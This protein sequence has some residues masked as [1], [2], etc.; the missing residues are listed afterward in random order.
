MA[1]PDEPPTIN[2]QDGLRSVYGEPLDLAVA[3]VRDHLDAHHV[4]FIQHSP[5]LCLSSVDRDGFPTV[6]PK[7]DAPGFVQVLDEHTLVIPDRPG[8]NK[9]ETLQNLLHSPQVGMILFVPGYKE[10][11]RIQG[12]ARISRD[13]AMRERGR[14]G[15]K[16]PVTA[17]V[18]SVTQAFI[19]CGKSTTRSKLWDASQHVEPGTLPSFG[20]IVKD[21]V[22][23]D[24]PVEEIQ[25][26]I[27][28]AYETKLY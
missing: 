19:H 5:F 27:D 9:I 21:Q 14:V 22:G 15:D 11:L 8:N 6:S 12:T 26:A 2:D 25:G 23:L 4:R 28:T 1:D 16:L 10:T 3:I 20:Q 24:S 18:V 13:E 17:L 7:G